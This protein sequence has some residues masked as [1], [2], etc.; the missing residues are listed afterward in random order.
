[1]ALGN[2]FFGLFSKPASVLLGE[3]SYSIYLLHGVVLY[4]VYSSWNLIDLSGMSAI[5]HFFWLPLVGSAVILMACLTFLLLEKPAIN[6]GKKLNS[7]PTSATIPTK[8]L[9]AEK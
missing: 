2:D 4:A 6:L 8:Q 5:N 3:I 7:R 9:L 1:V